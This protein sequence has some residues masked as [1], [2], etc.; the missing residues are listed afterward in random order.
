MTATKKLA[1]KDLSTFSES[2]LNTLF[3]YYKIPIALPKKQ[4]INLLIYH[5][6]SKKS[7]KAYSKKSAKKASL[8]EGTIWNA[9]QQDNY[10]NFLEFVNDSSFD[11]NVMFNGLTLLIFTLLNSAYMK[12]TEKYIEKLIEK[13]ADVNK[14]DNDGHSPLSTAVVE[15]NIKY[16]LLST[17]KLLLK[18]GADPN[19]KLKYYHGSQD[20]TYPID[21][22]I[23]DAAV[24]PNKFEYLQTILKLLLDYGAKI[25][26]NVVEIACTKFKEYQDTTLLDILINAPKSGDLS[27]IDIASI[28]DNW[29]RPD[30]KCHNYIIT[31]L[32]SRLDPYFEVFSSGEVEYLKT[33]CDLNTVKGIYKCLDM[34][35][36]MYEYHPLNEKA[37]ELEKKYKDHPY[38]KPKK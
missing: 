8:P 26:P 21:Y 23:N 28:N 16:N 35:E 33:E 31:K 11:K 36:N 7:A 1:K 4:K 25:T 14:T 38:Y 5:L 37:K 34:A 18:A 27:N 10:E 32:K 15:N 29:G 30:S 12:H 24:S 19:K 2:D 3:S 17:I 22:V 9:I 13:G 20:K 6:Y